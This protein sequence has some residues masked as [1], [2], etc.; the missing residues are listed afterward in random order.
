MRD[1]QQLAR[2]ELRARTLDAEHRVQLLENPR[3]M[4][5]NGA[6]LLLLQELNRVQQ[7]ITE[8]RMR[9]TAEP[10]P[11][12]LTDQLGEYQRIGE[13]MRSFAPPRAPSTASELELTVS[14]QKLNLE[15]QRI[16]RE[17]DAKLDAIREQAQG[18]RARDE[19]IAK[20]IESIPTWGAPLLQQWLNDR[21][22]GA[23]TE[24]ARPEQ[25]QAPMIQGGGPP[26]SLRE[27]QGT[28]PRCATA[29]AINPAGDR[30]PA[31]GL[32]LI[33]QAGQLVPIQ[34]PDEQ[35]ERFAS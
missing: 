25:A 24:S 18:Q 35:V 19:A 31:C 3:G 1:R 12:S 6:S 33:A 13:V 34:P 4:G 16:N 14:M 28:C 30:C 11:T 26:I 22:G 8:L 5:D 20:L 7:Q 15:N 32:E 21:N 27:T 29:I 9:S 10:R 2:L 17:L 23:N